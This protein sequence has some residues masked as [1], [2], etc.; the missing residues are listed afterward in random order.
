MRRGENDLK[1]FWLRKTQKLVMA[2]LLVVKPD[3]TRRVYKGT[4]MEVSRVKTTG[5]SSRT[6]ALFTG[7]DAHGQSLRGAECHWDCAV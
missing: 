2:V 4:N 7:F 5:L 6:D 3:G 1:S